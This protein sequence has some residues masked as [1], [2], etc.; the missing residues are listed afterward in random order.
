MNWLRRFLTRPPVV[1]VKD[2]LP[3]IAVR[4]QHNN[5]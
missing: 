2:V 3:D 4:Y 1:T 5:P